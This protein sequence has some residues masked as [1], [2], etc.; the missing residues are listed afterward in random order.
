MLIVDRVLGHATAPRFS[1]KPVDRVTIAAADAGRRRLR[2]RSAGGVDVAIDLPRGGW[3]ADGSV[4]HEDA[5]GALIVVVRPPELV[6]VVEVGRLAPQ[7]AFRIG[8]AL[9]NRHSPSDWHGDEIV[10]PVT[11]TQE[12]TARPLLALGL[13]DLVLRFEQRPFAA[14]EPPTCAGAVHEHP[15]PRH[16]HAAHG[17][18]HHTA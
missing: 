8:H 1:G 15:A 12:L 16:E 4:L 17:H 10:V 11:D 5:G 18:H 7:A 13:D 14:A 2:V 9:G 3:L 6:M